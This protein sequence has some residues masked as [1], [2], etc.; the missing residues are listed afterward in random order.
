MTKPIIIGEE[1]LK[2][3]E[4][5]AELFEKMSQTIGDLVK[6]NV[7]M[8]EDIKAMAKTVITLVSKVH[9]LEEEI[10]GE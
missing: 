10:K 8:R 4:Q 6:S 5:M 7:V 9:E 3:Q 2:N 1:A